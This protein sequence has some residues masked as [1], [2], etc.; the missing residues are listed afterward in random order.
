MMPLSALARPLAVATGL[1]ALNL[2]SAIAGEVEHGE[3][4]II[5]T[6]L[7][8]GA[9]WQIV[10]DYD[11]K[12]VDRHSA[13]IWDDQIKWSTTDGEHY[14]L[15]RKSGNLTVTVASTTGGYFLYDHCKLGN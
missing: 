1:L 5:C 4:A 12:T 3:K 8:S 14:A 9:K 13:S 15:D 6:N 2:A 7:S 10:I 11:H